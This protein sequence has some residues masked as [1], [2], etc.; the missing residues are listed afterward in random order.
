MLAK[1][2]ARE[3]ELTMPAIAEL[4]FE[5]RCILLK[6]KSQSERWWKELET[7]VFSDLFE[8]KVSKD[9]KL[10]EGRA[11]R[12]VTDE[13]QAVEDLQFYG[14]SEDE[15]YKKSLRG[16]GDIED[17]IRDLGYRRKDIPAMLA[18]FTTREAGQPT[19]APID[20]PKPSISISVDGVFDDHDTDMD[21]DEL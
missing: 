5:Q 2:D 7:S 10:V 11:R 21:D 3:Y 14:L 19:M 6:F 1:L 4:T 12:K 16:F 17:A 18:G 9:W 15:I 8:G 20:D 13:G